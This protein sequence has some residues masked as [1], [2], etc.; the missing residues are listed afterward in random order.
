[1]PSTNTTTVVL[2]PAAQAVKEDLAPIFGLKP[3]LSAGLVLFGRLTAEEQKRAI[4]DASG[5]IL[6]ED[7]YNND[8]LAGKVADILAKYGIREGSEP[9]SRSAGSKVRRGS[10][11]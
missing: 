4:A 7:L 6:S 3:I 1:M 5:H 10:V 9:G 2:T 11:A 8:V